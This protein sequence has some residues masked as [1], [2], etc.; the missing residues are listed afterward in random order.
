VSADQQQA[1]EKAGEEVKKS[2]EDKAKE[3]APD[4]TELLKK[5]PAKSG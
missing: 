1:T 2:A 3:A 4:E 5:K